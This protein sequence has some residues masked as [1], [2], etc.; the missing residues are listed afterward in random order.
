MRDIGKN[1]KS[2]RLSRK[3]TQEALAEALFVTRQTVSNYEN[4]KSRPD[5][6][7]LLKIA[8]VLSTDV[9]AVIY[10]PAVPQ[11]K[12]DRYKWLLISSGLLLAIAALY[13]IIDCLLPKDVFGYQHSVRLIMRLT[14]LP[15]VMFILGWVLIHSL[16]I[17]GG[18]QQLSSPKLKALRVTAL[19]LL[20]LLVVIPLPI[21]IFHGIAGYRS[22]LYH[23]VSMHFPHIPVYTEVYLIV[24]FVIFN[25]PFIYTIF[26]GICWL[27]GLPRITKKDI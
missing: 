23:N 14:L 19:I 24:Q 6:D 10:G 16:S 18:L 21:V 26:G 12:K 13:V 1:I 5:L 11:S 3:M 4:G 17:I 27:L 22:F 20:G 25:L 9:N 2:I 8:E 15:T 7:M